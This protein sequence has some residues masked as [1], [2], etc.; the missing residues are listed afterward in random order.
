M[1][2]WFCVGCISSLKCSNDSLLPSTKATNIWLEERMN[3]FKTL[4]FYIQL[5]HKLRCIKINCFCKLCYFKFNF[6]LLNSSCSWAIARIRSEVILK[7][8]SVTSSSVTSS[9]LTYSFSCRPNLTVW[10][11]IRWFR[12]SLDPSIAE[13]YWTTRRLSA[14]R[15]LSG[16][17][18]F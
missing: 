1:G 3:F 8:N 9:A 16:K 17:K 18:P 11:Q 14:T 5:F 6:L 2:D 13:Q 15:E 10:Y 12:S 7:S 4:L